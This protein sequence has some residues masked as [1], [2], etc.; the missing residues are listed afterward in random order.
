MDSRYP[1]TRGDLKETFINCAANEA[2]A[3]SIWKTIIQN[4]GGGRLDGLKLWV[5]GGDTYGD[6][7]GIFSISPI[8]HH[9]T[10]SWLI[11]RV[12]R[13]DLQDLTV[14]E[15]GQ[16][17]RDARVQEGVIDEAF[18]VYH[19]IWLSKE[20]S[21]NWRRDWWSFPPKA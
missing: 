8:C 4:K 16:H 3:C 11:E 14:R 18:Q 10:R 1:P 21:E 15:L 20:A 17:V 6:G 2:L 7:G 13:D 9:L 12:P 5:V 19:S